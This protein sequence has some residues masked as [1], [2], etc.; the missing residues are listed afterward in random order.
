MLAVI[1]THAHVAVGKTVKHCRNS[2]SNMVLVLGL[3]QDCRAS[4]LRDGAPDKAHMAVRSSSPDSGMYATVPAHGFKLLQCA[5]A[6]LNGMCF[7]CLQVRHSFV[8]DSK[9]VPCI[10]A[11]LLL[12]QVSVGQLS[13]T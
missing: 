2:C 8:A 9:P 5:T 6:N 13:A 12:D 7:E 1:R 11:G 3:L 4:L 10:T